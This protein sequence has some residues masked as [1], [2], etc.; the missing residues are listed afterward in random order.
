MIGVQT[1]A[2]QSQLDWRYLGREA[3]L[4]VLFAW[5]LP[6]A[7]GMDGLISFRGQA[8]SAVLFTLVAGAWLAHRLWQRRTLPATGLE[9]PLILLVLVQAASAA[10]AEVP[11]LS[12]PAI[13][14]TLAYIVLFY[15]ALDLARSGWPAE[16][17]EKC[18]LIGGAIVLALAALDLANAL[19]GWLA[20]RDLP[21]PPPFEHRLYAVVG[22]AN[23]LAGFTNILWPLALARLLTTRSA[24]SRVLLGTL[25][26]LALIVQAFCYSRGATL[27]LA[28][29][30]L[31]F[32]AAWIGLV[33]AT[34][35]RQ[36]TRLW[37]W[38]VANPIWLVGLCLAGAAFGAALGW[39][40]LVTR[41]SATQAPAA[42]AR[43]TFWGV[44]WDALQAQPWLGLGPGA[45]PQ[46]MGV[47]IS[48]PPEHLFMNAHSLIFNTLAE[49]GWSG[50]TAGSLLLAALAW[51]LWR[52]R[53]V[54][55]LADRARWAATAAAWTAFLAHGL[56]DYHVRYLA[57]A[58]PLLVSAAFVLA[59]QPQPERRRG[60][61]PWSIAWLAP[62]ALSAAVFSAFQLTAAFRLEQATL[63]GRADDWTFAA[64]RADQAASADPAFGLYAAQSGYAYA[65]LAQAASGDEAD[66]ARDAA[67]ARYVAALE[68][69]PQ[70]AVWELNLGVLVQADG[71]QVAGLAHLAQAQALAP[72][73]GLPAMLRGLWIEDAAEVDA[74]SAYADALTREPALAASAMWGATDLRRGV[75]A[76]WQANTPATTPSLDIQIQS[77][78]AMGKLPDAQQLIERAW[79]LSP[80]SPWV[81]RAFSSLAAAQGSPTLAERYL[82][83]SQWLQTVAVRDHITAALLRGRQAE[84]S[85]ALDTAKDQYAFAWQAGTQV[86]PYG[87][88]FLGYIPH[89]HFVFQRDTWAGEL[90]PQTPQ[91]DFDAT[92]AD[93][94]A[95]LLADQPTLAPMT[96][97]ELQAVQVGSVQP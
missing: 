45:F 27:A 2:A 18:L 36:V 26:V 91:V 54:E 43:S 48:A 17:V 51:A 69:G 52:A 31:V 71:D 76:Q 21:Y 63:A 85:G 89:A 24:L 57:L 97:A 5:A 94:F 67:I 58:I 42:E 35:R 12:L 75:L 20:L 23:I 96:A 8:G 32:G 49:T 65:Q 55:P 83:A 19:Q 74:R 73:W 34:L 6:I 93:V 60:P 72:K 1:R 28:A 22:D 68:A 37:R 4:I 46:A 33:S 16:L 90:V 50:L 80:S 88:G 3:L 95:D 59:A 40:L 38:L 78:L 9:L 66:A 64:Q 30:G 15:L 62:V 82:Q 41:N 10:L 13:A 53:T 79:T 92:L 25:V 44:A 70:L 61:R 77:L 7:G 81:Y 84:Q 56:V 14:Q 39:R 87:W 11:R 29:G 47:A 86:S